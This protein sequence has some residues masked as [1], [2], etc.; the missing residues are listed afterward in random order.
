VSLEDTRLSGFF[1]QQIDGRWLGTGTI[2]VGTVKLNGS[3]SAGTQGTFAAMS[4][5][6]NEVK[7][8]ESFGYPI[9]IVD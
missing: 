1:E 6:A 7:A 4:L 3:G 2:S 5:G 9:P 8:V